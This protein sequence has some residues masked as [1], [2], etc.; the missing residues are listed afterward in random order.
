MTL[1]ELYL[2]S[3]YHNIKKIYCLKASADKFMTL[4]LL[5]ILKLIVEIINILNKLTVFIEDSKQA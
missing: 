2:L 4:L 3:L 5:F 1:N